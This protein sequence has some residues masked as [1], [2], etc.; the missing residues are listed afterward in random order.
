MK[1]AQLL[2][3]VVPSFAPAVA[4]MKTDRSPETETRLAAQVITDLE[5]MARVSKSASVERK[6]IIS[7][8]A[9]FFETDEARAAV[10]N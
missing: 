10:H 1:F 2:M 4:V 7:N 3:Q 6:R 8:L 9:F 5:N